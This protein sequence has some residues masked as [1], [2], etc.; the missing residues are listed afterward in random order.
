MGLQVARRQGVSVYSRHNS[1]PDQTATLPL[2][3]NLASTLKVA[4]SLCTMSVRLSSGTNELLRACHFSYAFMSSTRP[5][6]RLG[7]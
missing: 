1:N 4:P 7:V 2:A 5:A 3:S 6:M